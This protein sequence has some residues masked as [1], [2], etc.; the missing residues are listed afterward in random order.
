MY[1]DLWENGIDM[2]A[3]ERAAS[4]RGKCPPLTELEQRRAMV[5]MTELGV[6]EKDIAARL[7]LASRTVARWRRAMG[8]VA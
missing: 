6:A 4:M 5:L 3:V 7:G 1:G 8:L 2:A